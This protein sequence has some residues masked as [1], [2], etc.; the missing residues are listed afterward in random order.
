MDEMIVVSEIGDEWSPKIPPA[1]EA[2][3]NG[4]RENP[5]T[6][7]AGTA[8]GSIIAKVPHDDPMEKAIPAE[9]RKTRGRKATGGRTP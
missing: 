1:N 3:T 5:M 2:A 4:A 8:I 6:S 9:T 7:A